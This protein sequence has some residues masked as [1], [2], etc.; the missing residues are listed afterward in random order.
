M[1][2]VL[3]GVR[4]LDGVVPPGVVDSPVP[5]NEH[6]ALNPATPTA[7]SATLRLTRRSGR[8]SASSPM[9]RPPVPLARHHHPKLDK[10][11]TV[12]LMT[13]DPLPAQMIVHPG[14]PL[15]RVLGEGTT[16]LADV[17]DEG[18]LG[19]PGPGRAGLRPCQEEFGDTPSVVAGSGH[20]GMH[21]GR[22]LCT[23]GRPRTI[24]TPG[25]Q[26]RDVP[27][28]S[29]AHEVRSEARATHEAEQA[30]HHQ[31]RPV[32]AADVLEL[33]LWV[34]NE[35][36]VA[37]HLVRAG[38]VDHDGCVSLSRIN[39]CAVPTADEVGPQ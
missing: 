35:Q 22:S 19:C 4:E 32:L 14:G 3:V 21:H 25:H 16:S 28:R 31:G 37:D 27:P 33:A 8:G 5:G 30:E 13:G 29:S 1:L 7:P 6:P 15:R 2:E 10:S 9:R 11:A 18:E 17:G 23:N 39:E 12:T 36:K 26:A 38:R 24:P 34:Q 20:D